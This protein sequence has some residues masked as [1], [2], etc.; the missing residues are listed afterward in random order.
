VPEYLIM[1]HTGHRTERSCA[2]HEQ[3][4]LWEDN[5]AAMLGL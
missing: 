3:G 5:P 1:R 4:A 2:V